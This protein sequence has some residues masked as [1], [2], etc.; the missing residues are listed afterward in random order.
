MHSQPSNVTEGRLDG[1]GVWRV[2][3]R[4]QQ[5]SQA[6]RLA[7]LFLFF[8][9]LSSLLCLFVRTLCWQGCISVLLP[10]PPRLHVVTALTKLTLTPYFHINPHSFLLVVT[11]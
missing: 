4:W 5:A 3:V 8:F 9:G 11:T 1:G 2:K 7:K 10:F 6:A